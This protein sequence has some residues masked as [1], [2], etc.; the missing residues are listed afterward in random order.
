[1]LGIRRVTRTAFICALLTS[2]GCSYRA[3]DSAS[4]DSTTDTEGGKSGAEAAGGGGAA[5]SSNLTDADGGEAGQP[6][7][8][9]GCAS[10]ACLKDGSCVECTPQ[11]DRCPKGE[12]CSSENEC[13]RGCKNGTTSCASGVCGKD[14]NC[15][16]CIDDSECI[17]GYTCSGGECMEACG[18]AQEGTSKG[19]GG[20]MICCS[21]RCSNLAENRNCGACG[22]SCA[23][24]Q[25]CGLSACA[26][27]GEGGGSGAD[28]ALCVECHD[29]TLASV[30]SVAKVTVILDS[31]KNPT[32]GNRVPGRAVGVALRDSCSTSPKLLE[33][34]QDSISALNLTTGRPVSDG[35]ELLVVAGGA[36]YQNLEGYLEGR[37]IT[38]LYLNY[39]NDVT[40]FRRTGTNKIVASLPMA[41]DHDSHDIFIIQFMRDPASGS[42]ILNEQG[43]WLSGTV[44]GAY[45][46]VHGLLPQLDR[47]DQA[48]YA[49]EWTDAD[50]DKA[51]DLGE[52][53]LLDSGK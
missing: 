35:S 38:P 2:A 31:S 41:G 49:Y 12:Y 22:N 25:F 16:R 29:T 4:E 21:E 3:S 43:F 47:Q 1:M 18:S 52:I 53:K 27:A 36:F 7:Q 50:G 9:A 20:D 51:P 42:L 33:A 40:E 45:Q 37:Q 32:D 44:A 23:S 28:S 48:W 13:T 10:G 39:T 11:N 6:A 24:G 15:K 8:C 30:C 46:M 19:C 14:H 17:A 34:E 26:E 5:A